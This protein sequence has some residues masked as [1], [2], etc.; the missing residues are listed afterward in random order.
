MT[1]I[2][3]SRGCPY[4]CYFC[5]QGREPYR[6]RS[7]ASVVDEIVDCMQQGF[8]DFFFA[9]DT[10]NINK[11]KVIDFCNELIT[12]NLNISWCCKC[13]VNGMDYETLQ[14][15]ARAGCYL[16]NF[17]IET[18]SDAGLKSIRKGTTTKRFSWVGRI[19]TVISD[20]SNK[21][22][23]ATSWNETMTI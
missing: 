9:E 13:R 17:G 5:P 4:D 2:V 14:A 10:F 22:Q 8:T 23:A 19:T 21:D 15:M 1:T 3:S 16:I 20:T 6:Q 18:G 11:T 12:R 7:S